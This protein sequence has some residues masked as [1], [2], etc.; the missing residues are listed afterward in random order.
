MTTVRVR[1]F[2]SLRELAGA[3]EVPGQGDSVDEV[4]AELSGR[5]GERFAEIA[6]AGSF[7]VDG[8]RAEPER[9]LADGAEVAL[10]PPFSGG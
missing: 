9:P 5:Y 4:V 10:L 3:S 1:L 8:E 7:V 6:R 2:A